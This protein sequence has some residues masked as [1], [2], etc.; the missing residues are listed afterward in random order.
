MSTE[1]E[2]SARISVATKAIEKDYGHVIKWLGDAAKEEREY[3][4]TGCIGLDNAVGRGGFERGLIVEVYGHEGAGKSFL[5]YSTMLEACKQGHKCAIVDAE[6]SLDTGLLIKVGLP[7]DKVVVADGAPTGEANLNIAQTLMETGEF[8]VVMID[9]VAALVPEARME[10]AYDQQSI[11]LHARL[12]SA[13]IQKILPVVKRTNTLLIFINQIRNKIGSYGCFHYDTLVNFTDGRSLPI[14]KIVEEKIQGNVWTMDVTT[15][16]IINKP[17]VGWHDNGKISKDEQFLHIETSSINGKGRFGFTC[18]P[19]H[20]VLTNKGWM[21]A[22]ELSLEDSLVSKYS[23]TLNGTYG[24]FMKGIFVGDSHISVR[25][26]NTG[27]LRLQDNENLEYLKWKLDKLQPFI[28]FKQIKV[29]RGYRYCS[30]YS[31]E[32]SKIKKMLGNRNP[33]FML[34][35][36]SDIAMA[37]WIMDD[38]NLDLNS[39]HC[40]YTLSVKR[41]KNNKEMLEQITNKLEELG[42]PCTSYLKQ[43]TIIFDKVASLKIASHICSYIPESMQYKLPEQFRGK[44]V[45]FYLSNSEKIKA[46]LVKITEIRNASSRQ[47]RNKRKFDISIEETH[48]YMVGGFNNGVVVHNSPETTTGGK[49][50]PFYAAYRI[51][52]RGGQSKSS[53]LLDPGTGEVY[54]HRTTFK[55]V[56]NKRAAP[57]KEAEVDLIYGL[58]YDTQG[59]LVDLAIDMGV[60]DKGGA[61][62]S[63]GDIKW[64]GRD[65]AKLAIMSDP[66][67]K[68]ELE[69][70]LRNLIS[71]NV[72]DE[73]SSEEKE[74]VQTEETESK[75]SNDKPPSKRSTR[76]SKTSIS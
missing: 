42:F 56:K 23:N 41:F 63:Y 8:A 66:S 19:D 40:R 10:A 47:M 48:N 21:K 35:D 53:K 24:K 15:G 39:G 46:D 1:K 49:A 6:N 67:L 7:P 58:G 59:E 16:Q 51:E 34:E 54:G 61:W 72:P 57:W 36:Y 69:I 43:G 62:L 55:V 4:P 30:P 60:I 29:S 50:L 64:Q 26:K 2:S 14:G 44:Y 76:K 11:G 18:T 37:V 22:K 38:G 33:L 74:S 13:G 27:S 28:D 9:S 12:L 45:D 20:K 68:K 52:V 65:R 3:I 5:G 25:H 75:K 17:I 31:Y 73:T 70:K 71:G 32:F